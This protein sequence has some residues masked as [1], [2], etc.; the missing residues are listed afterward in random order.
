MFFSAKSEADINNLI[1][2]GVDIN[3]QDSFFGQTFLHIL[4]QTGSPLLD[5]FLTKGPNTNIANKAGKTPLYYAKDVKTVEKLIF[6]GASVLVKDLD[7]NTI[8]DV[9]P[10]LMANYITFYTNKIKNK[11]A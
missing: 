9:N 5:Y 3:A 7:G 2:K 10:R 11:V 1:S 6:H 8:N 4:V